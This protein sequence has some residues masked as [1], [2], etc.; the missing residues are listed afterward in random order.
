MEYG[1]L[2]LPVGISEWFD[3]VLSYPGV[4]VL[5]LTPQIAA[6]STQLPGNFHADPWDQLI[7]ATARVHGC[8]LVTSD[9]QIIRY[10]HVTTIG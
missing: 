3:K 8:S 6:E 9:R 2:E 5:E 1:R 10:P 7:V 4:S